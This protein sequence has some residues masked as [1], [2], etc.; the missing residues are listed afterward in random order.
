[1]KLYKSLSSLNKHIKSQHS[2]ST[3]QKNNNGH[4]SLM[5]Y[6]KCINKK[7]PSKKSL[8]LHQSQIHNNNNS[9]N[10]ED[11]KDRYLRLNYDRM[12]KKKRKHNGNWEIHI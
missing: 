1:M 5:A 3:N 11:T 8:Q 2:R 7:I 10:I 6:N 4:Q 12:D 9:M